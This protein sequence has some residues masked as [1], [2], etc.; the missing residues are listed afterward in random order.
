MKQEWLKSDDHSDRW[1]CFL[2][3]DDHVDVL[4]RL[5]PTQK[6]HRNGMTLDEARVLWNALVLQHWH[7]CSDD[8]IDAHAMS[9]RRL[10]EIIYGE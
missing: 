8:E 3:F 6:I 5:G 7:H 2:V 1:C 9:H 4:A 10:R